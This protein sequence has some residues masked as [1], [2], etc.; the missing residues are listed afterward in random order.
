MEKLSKEEFDRLLK[1]AGKEF[2]KSYMAASAAIDYAEAGELAIEKLG[3]K[4]N[5]IKMNLN[6]L[7]NQFDN[8]LQDFKKYIEKGDSLVIL[9]DFENIKPQ[10]DK[11]FDAEL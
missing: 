3:F 9:K 11:I 8:F 1:L 5:E 10:L 2:A 7:M 4:R 6:R